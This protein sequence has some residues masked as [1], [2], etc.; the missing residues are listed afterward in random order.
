[1]PCVL[2]YLRTFLPGIEGAVGP[3]RQHT[4]FSITVMKEG[5]GDNDAGM[6]ITRRCCSCENDCLIIICDLASAVP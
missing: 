4:V 6:D 3:A 5:E 2:K 1:M